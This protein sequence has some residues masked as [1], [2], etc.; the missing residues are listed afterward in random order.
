[1]RIRFTCQL[2]CRC[3][4]AG[5]GGTALPSQRVQLHTENCAVPVDTALCC[6]PSYVT[7]ALGAAVRVS[8]LQA[9]SAATGRKD[10]AIKADYEESGDLGSVAAACRSVGWGVSAW[11]C[12]FVW[13]QKPQLQP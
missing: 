13:T 3:C 5:T 10:A 11:R 7:V 2:L 6:C 9:L 1:M 12:N 4:A 8:L